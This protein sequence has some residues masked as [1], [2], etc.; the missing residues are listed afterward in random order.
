MISSF[1]Q[2]WYD[3][4]TNTMEAFVM[5]VLVVLAFSLCVFCGTALA[6]DR[7]TV[8][9]PLGEIDVSCIAVNARSFSFEGVKGDTYVNKKRGFVLSIP[10][11]DR[12]EIR[13]SPRVPETLF[14]IPVVIVS[15]KAIDNFKASVS[16]FLEPLGKDIAIGPYVETSV[17]H[18]GKSGKNVLAYKVD[19]KTSAG[20]V[21][22]SG[23]EQGTAISSVQRLTV[24]DG[25]GY[26]ITANSLVGEKTSPEMKTD[27]RD[28]LNSFK[29]LQVQNE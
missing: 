8:D 7:V 10:N 19:T 27:L 13:E 21:E 16:V 6:D 1:A 3:S 15:T 25:L 24:Q 29:L 4:D 17:F 28:I 12:W 11:A 23:S 18:L 20:Y 26:V 2:A 22:S 14:E 9:S 5:N